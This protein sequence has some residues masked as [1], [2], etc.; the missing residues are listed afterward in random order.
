MILAEWALIPVYLQCLTAVKTLGRNP[1]GSETLLETNHLNIL[2]QHTGLPIPG[3]NARPTS[4][5]ALEALRV[6]ANLLVLH[7]AGRSRFAKAG[8]AKAIALAL[9]GKDAEGEVM[10]EE[11]TAERLFLLGRIGFLVTVDRK[12]SV[13]IMVDEHNIVESIVYVS[14]S[15]CQD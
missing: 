8:G 1:M 11:E 5:T 13:G 12:D 9:A 15:R 2:L 3:S 7:A 14:F 10:D 4:A 6:L